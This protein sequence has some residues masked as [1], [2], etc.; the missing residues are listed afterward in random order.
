MLLGFKRQFAPFVEEGS[1]THTIRARRLIRPRVGEICHCFVDPRQ[2][3]MR[4]L[5][6]FPC[7]RVEPVTIIIPPDAPIEIWIAGVCLSPGEANAF[8]WRDG[9]RPELRCEA[10]GAMRLFWQAV[11]GR[12]FFDVR[13][14]MIFDGDLIHWRF[15]PRSVGA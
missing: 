10:A 15:F 4:L 5:G 1:K 14:R 6:R 3:T 7:V 9:F 8:A 13:G 11:H 2:K 12:K